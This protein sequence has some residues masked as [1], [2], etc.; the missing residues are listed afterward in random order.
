[1]PIF[2]VKTNDNNGVD[3]TVVRERQNIHNIKI[4][5]ALSYCDFIRHQ[6]EILKNKSFLRIL[7]R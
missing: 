3:Y 7:Y 2:N 5:K 4:N 1:M 6:Y